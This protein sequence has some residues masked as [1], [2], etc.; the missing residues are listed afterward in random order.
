M[1]N[2]EKQ[3]NPYL[4]D[5]TQ[6]V[7]TSGRPL[8]QSIFLETQYSHYAVYSLKDEDYEYNGKIY[9]SIKKLYLETNDPTEY[10]FAT[11]YLLGVKHWYRI[12]ENKLLKDHVS[13]WR[14][15]MELKLRS[16][17][18]KQLISASH[19]GS[20]SASKYLAD[21]GWDTRAAGRPSSE[22]LEREKKIRLNI[23]EEYSEDIKRLA[24]IK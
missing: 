22:E 13:E 2:I 16:Q 18:V 11:K 14:F 3:E 15:E 12:A 10:E 19:K 20:Q 9:P 6:L 23:T 21:R 24:I 7:D 4:P 5:K 1:S 17:G 8:T